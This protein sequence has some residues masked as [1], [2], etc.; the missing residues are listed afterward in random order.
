MWYS[1]PLLAISLFFIGLFSERLVRYVSTLSK[2]F[3]L[4]EMAA[5]FILLSVATSLPELSFEIAAVRKRQVDMVF[6]DLLGS[7]VA[8][9]T[10]VLGLTALIQPIFLEKG[11]NAYLLATVF[12]AVIFCFFWLFVKSKKK[13]ERWEGIVLLL[14]YVLFILAEFLRL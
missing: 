11:L 1:I 7:V 13:L 2:V 4:S 12:F 5:G 3:G 6:G 14:I 9:S 10:L 8:N